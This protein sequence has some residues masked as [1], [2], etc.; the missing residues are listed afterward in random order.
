MAVCPAVQAPLAAA[1]L[2]DMAVRTDRQT[3]RSRWRTARHA[4][5]NQTIL[6]VLLDS[7]GRVSIFAGLASLLMLWSRGSVGVRQRNYM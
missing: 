7:T 2:Q 3:G 5:T 4:Q 6:L 1:S